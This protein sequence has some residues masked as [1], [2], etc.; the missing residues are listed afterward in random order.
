MNEP[1][2]NIGNSQKEKI[3]TQQIKIAKNVFIYN[4]TFIP[5]HSISQVSVIKEKEKPYS[6]N[7]LIA[8]V[9][10]IIFLFWGNIATVIGFAII[11]AAIYML[12]TTYRYNKEIGE[13]LK[14]EM[15][16]GKNIYFYNKNHT[17]LVEIM[18]VMINCINTHNEYLVSMDTYNIKSCQFGNNNL[19]TNQSW[20]EV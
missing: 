16:S 20:R 17:F 15:N 3:E 1:K 18:D 5:L 9:V 19:M 11:V 4:N 7:Q 14:I 2:I 10:G 8:V 12:Y 13:Y 6:S